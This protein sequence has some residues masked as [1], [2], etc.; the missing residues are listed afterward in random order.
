L[1]LIP[2]WL[3]KSTTHP[4]AIVIP[5]HDYSHQPIVNV[6]SFDDTETSLDMDFL[7]N[8]EVQAGAEVISNIEHGILTG[9]SVGFTIQAR[10]VEERGKGREKYFVQRITK[11]DL[12]EVSTVSFPAIA[13]ARIK[14]DASADAVTFA[15][16]DKVRP[17]IGMAKHDSVGQQVRLA[18]FMGVSKAQATCGK[19]NAGSLV[20]LDAALDQLLDMGRKQV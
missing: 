8:P 11:A 6:E 16:A 1:Q 5:N 18:T 7:L 12:F 19:D 4:T 13:G 20:A 14:N 2:K 9:L 15:I 3:A 10:E 17:R